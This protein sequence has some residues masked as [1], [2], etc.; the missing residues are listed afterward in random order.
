MP[1]SSEHMEA[2]DVTGREDWELKERCLFYV[3]QSR[4]EGRAGGHGVRVSQ[5]IG[6][7]T[8]VNRG[9]LELDPIAEWLR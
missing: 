7:A 4:G 9:G 8:V 6:G 3:A 5:P 2:A 1:L